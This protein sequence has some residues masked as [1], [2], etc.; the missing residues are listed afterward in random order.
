MSRDD[1]SALP[2]QQLPPWKSACFVFVSSSFTIGLLKLVAMISGT[3]LVFPSLGPTAFMLFHEP[4]Q[5]AA[6]P[7]TTICGHA[8]GILCGFTSLWLT[9]LADDP[10]TMVEHVNLPRVICAALAL[11]T[12]G[13]GMLLLGVWHPP[14]GATTLIVSL[15]FITRPYHLLVV[16]LA[17]VA[18]VVMAGVI[19]WV[20]GLRSTAS[21]GGA[22]R[23]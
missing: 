12:T 20:V 23:R 22:V 4:W 10:P 15:G 1:P 17:V 6:R 5:R 9:G 19:N 2:A 7:L 18:L 11:G 14:A 8:I 16:E 13:I 3:P 21:D